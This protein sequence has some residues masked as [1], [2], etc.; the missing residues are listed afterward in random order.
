MCRMLEV[1]TSGY[2]AWCQRPPPPRARADAELSSR[3]RAIH[4]RSRGT[5]GAPR[6]SRLI[7]GWAMETHLRTELAL[8][9]LHMALGQR[10]PTGVIHHSG[11]GTWYTSI[12]FGMRCRKLGV[13][14]SMGSVG[15]CLDNAMCESFFARLECELLDRSSFHTQAEA[16]MAAFEFIEDWYNPHRRHSAID[17]L[18]PINYA[19]NHQSQGLPQARRRPLNRGNSSLPGGLTLNANIQQ[20]AKG[21]AASAPAPMPP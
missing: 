7:V 2:Y 17:H 9:A 6:I 16:R 13:R 19:R 3:M 20:F 5:C 12:A 15:D 11:Q 8:E 21:A 10:R 4:E 1:S 18:S 14:P